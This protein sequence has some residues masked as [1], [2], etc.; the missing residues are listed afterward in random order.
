MPETI[1]QNKDYSRENEAGRQLEEKIEKLF[2]QRYSMSKAGGS[3]CFE[4]E[5]KKLDL[6]ILVL[7]LDLSLFK[8]LFSKEVKDS[9]YQKSIEE[10]ES[11]K[12]VIDFGSCVF[13]SYV[14]AK[15]RC[16]LEKGRFMQYFTK[17]FICIIHEEA[18][19]YKK[20]IQHGLKG[21]N[22]KKLSFVSLDSYCNDGKQILS[23]TIS[24][25][26]KD[27]IDILVENEEINRLFTKIDCIYKETKAGQKNKSVAYT[28]KVLDYLLSLPASATEQ[29]I[30]KY[31]FL[32]PQKENILHFFQDEGSVIKH[33]SQVIYAEICKTAN[34]VISRTCKE[35]VNRLKA[36]ED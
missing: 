19:V 4:K 1:Q 21:V 35:L 9:F 28:Y 27:Q 34:V 11:I 10:L 24:S 15:E 26:D 25:H 13:E 22:K 30:E 7:L 18:N 32:K 31:D 17:V 8:N 16:K 12:E 29:L 36:L 3:G 5:I 14:K 23:D 6:K 2:Q 33:V 20:E